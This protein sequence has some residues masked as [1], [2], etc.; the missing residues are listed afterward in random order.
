MKNLATYVSGMPSLE[1]L[2]IAG[3]IVAEKRGEKSL[4]IK[5]IFEGL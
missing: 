4:A 3:N 2:D 1:I 5:N